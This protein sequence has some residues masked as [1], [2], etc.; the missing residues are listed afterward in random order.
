[1]QVRL[2]I[3][4]A[5]S[6]FLVTASTGL[7]QA[8]ERDQEGGIRSLSFVPTGIPF[9]TAASPWSSIDDP[10]ERGAFLIW[11]FAS[12]S[13]RYASPLS[14]LSLDL[15]RGDYGPYD[16]LSDPDRVRLLVKTSDRLDQLTLERAV[17]ALG[18]Q[19][20]QDRTGRLLAV[21]I[22]PGRIPTLASYEWVLAVDLDRSADR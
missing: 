12:P 11:T 17:R 4:I 18:S 2:L 7:A 21:R 5:V 10:P 15:Q 16:L 8:P 20:V 13:P 3:S 1:M 19:I 9:G 14:K 6:V 22:E